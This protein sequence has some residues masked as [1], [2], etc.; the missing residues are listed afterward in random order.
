MQRRPKWSP[1]QLIHRTGDPGI[2]LYMQAPYRKKPIC[3]TC[4]FLMGEG[5][6]AVERDGE[7]KVIPCPTCALWRWEHREEVAT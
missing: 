2:P 6:V 3:P 7:L 5:V 1:E 4:G